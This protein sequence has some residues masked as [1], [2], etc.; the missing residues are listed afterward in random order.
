MANVNSY[1]ST[2]ITP[3]KLKISHTALYKRAFLL[4]LLSLPFFAAAWDKPDSSKLGYFLYKIG[5]LDIAQ[6]APGFTGAVAL[7]IIGLARLNT[8]WVQAVV[9]LLAAAGLFNAEDLVVSLGAPIE[10]MMFLGAF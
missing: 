7:A 2:F 6:G 4:V 8:S 5:V 3:M 9:S 1:F 10:L